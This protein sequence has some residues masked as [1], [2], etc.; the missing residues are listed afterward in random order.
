MGDVIEFRRRAASVERESAATDAPAPPDSADTEAPRVF[1][2]IEEAS[3]KALGRKGLSRRELER[4]LARQGY[5]ETA[6]ADEL[7]RCE[8]AGLIDDYALAQHLVVQLQER[9]GLAGSAIAAELAK[10]VIAPGAIEYAL[11]LVDSSDEL[12]R[13]RAIAEQRARRYQAL[14]Q[15]TIERRLTAYLMRRG[16][17]STAIRAAIAGLRSA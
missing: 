17:S 7:E 12:A 2:P 1:A 11:D 15:A 10:R 14:D 6:I 9:K 16:F 3:L 13:A 4:A 5:D 8:S